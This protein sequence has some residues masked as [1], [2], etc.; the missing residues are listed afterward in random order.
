MAASITTTGLTALRDAAKP[1]AGYIAISTDATAFDPSQT[2]ANPGGGGTNAVKAA[3]V[4]D[5]DA[6]SFKSSATFT[7]PADVPDGT[8]VRSVSVMPAESLANPTARFNIDSVVMSST[9]SLT[10]DATFTQSDAG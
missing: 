6:T 2:A 3:S 9:R 4:S 7:A 10:V 1:L 8:D 5:V